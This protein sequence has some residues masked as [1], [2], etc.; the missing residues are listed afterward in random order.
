MRPRK[1]L[2][3]AVTLAL[4]ASILLVLPI[5]VHRM[6]AWLAARPSPIPAT[7]QQQQAIV[8]A[9]ADPAEIWQLSLPWQLPPRQ[10]PWLVVPDHTTLP[11]NH[12]SNASL[13]VSCT[14]FGYWLQSKY[15]Q[16]PRKLRRD[17]I[18]AN[19]KSVPLAQPKSSQ[20][21]MVPG[22]KLHPQ[23]EVP[24]WWRSFYASYPQA[25]GLLRFSRASLS[26]DQRTAL[27]LVTSDCSSAMGRGAVIVLHHESGQWRPDLHA[28]AGWFAPLPAATE[29]TED[30]TLPDLLVNAIGPPCEYP[31]EKQ[32]IPHIP[33][34]H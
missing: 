3:L 24:A 20:L 14:G 19:R 30:A 26:K 6:Q 23:T 17:L 15:P 2:A 28:S 25:D 34:S 4:A 31:P 32:Q 11:C 22:D 16:I 33:Q 13:E 9:L 8:A 29:I 5:A 27:I 21:H 10:E 18:A 7:P 1:I 12:G